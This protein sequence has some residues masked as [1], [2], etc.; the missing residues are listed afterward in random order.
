MYSTLLS[1][2]TR[3]PKD[4][5]RESVSCKKTCFCGVKSQ[6]YRD[7]KLGILQCLESDTVSFNATQSL[8]YSTV[9]NRGG[10]TEAEVYVC[11]L[12]SWTTHGLME[13]SVWMMH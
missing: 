11:V 3:I 12:W 6:E 4:K 9:L 5:T 7:E 10:N 1:L 2:A 13:Y 8:G